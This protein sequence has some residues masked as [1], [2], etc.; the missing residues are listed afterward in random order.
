MRLH[1]LPL[2]L[3]CFLFLLGFSALPESAYAEGERGIEAAAA[4]HADAHAIPV[5]L[6]SMNYPTAATPTPTPRFPLTSPSYY[7]TSMDSEKIIRQGLCFG[8]KG[9]KPGR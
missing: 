9:L 5:F 1:Y 8:E 2:V 3:F 4:I 7:M 6:S